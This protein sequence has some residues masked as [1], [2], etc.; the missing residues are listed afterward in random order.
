MMKGSGMITIKGQGFIM[1][2]VRNYIVRPGEMHSIEL[3]KDAILTCVCSH[4][5][6]KSDDYEK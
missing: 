2:P 5:Y 6:D 4:P 1:T 3:Q